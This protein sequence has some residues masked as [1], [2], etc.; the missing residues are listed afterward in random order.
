MSSGSWV[1]WVTLGWYLI[2]LCLNFPL[3]KQSYS[4]ELAWKELPQIK[5]P[6]SREHLHTG[7]TA[8]P[9]SAWGLHQAGFLRCQGP[10]ALSIASS[11]LCPRSGPVSLVVWEQG[12][13][14]WHLGPA[15]PTG[16]GAASLGDGRPLRRACLTSGL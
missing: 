9:G 5:H 12:W 10:S 14:Q 7:N 11:Q 8:L 4:M 2:S 3:M 16:W 1:T 15:H 13:T 6:G